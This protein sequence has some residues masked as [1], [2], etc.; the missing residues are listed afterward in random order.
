MRI[1]SA[2]WRVKCGM[3]VCGI[4][5]KWTFT[6]LETYK[7]NIINN[8]KR[9]NILLASKAKHSSTSQVTIR[10]YIKAKSCR[11]FEKFHIVSLKSA[12]LLYIVSDR[13]IVC[14]SCF[15]VLFDVQSS[16][17]L[18]YP[19]RHRASTSMYSLTLCVRVMLP[20]RHQWKPAV[21]AV[22]VML[23]TPPSTASHRPAAPAHPAERSH[24]VVISRNGR[25]LV[26]RLRVMLP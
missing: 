9:K 24:C 2:E 4:S 19:T 15:S 13:C 20:E 23:R 3:K 17:E 8:I 10:G 12:K 6:K 11:L 25:K 5:L 16:I 1:F 7:C 22:A 21:Q 18:L 14:L 26:T